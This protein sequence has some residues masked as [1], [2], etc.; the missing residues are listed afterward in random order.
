MKIINLHICW[1]NM[2]FV[3]DW[4]FVKNK[5]N[6]WVETSGISAYRRYIGKT[7]SHLLLLWPAVHI[8]FLL[9]W[10]LFK[11]VGLVPK[12]LRDKPIG[13]GGRQSSIKSIII[14]QIIVFDFTSPHPFPASCWRCQH[15]GGESS[16]CRA[17]LPP[18]KAAPCCSW[19]F[20]SLLKIFIEYEVD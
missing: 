8:I 3:Y 17:C 15:R 2:I 4:N 13:F 1:E 12:S 11:E 16:R 20:W 6:G 9:L 5:K 18:P 19:I 7:V 10:L 14:S